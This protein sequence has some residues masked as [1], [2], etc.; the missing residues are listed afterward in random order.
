MTMTNKR[1][2]GTAVIAA[3]LALSMSGPARAA[4]TCTVSMFE[5]MR[6]AIEFRCDPF[7]CPDGRSGFVRCVKRAITDPLLGGAQNACA[8][9]LSDAYVRSTYCSKNVNAVACH[10]T[11]AKNVERCR[12]VPKPEACRAPKGGTACTSPFS[13]G[14]A[15]F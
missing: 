3:A 2:I 12:I 14:E 4:G 15:C 6:N 5:Q 8:P 11:T 7:G 10:A 1:S 9:L 13:C